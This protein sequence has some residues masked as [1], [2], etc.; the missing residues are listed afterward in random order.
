MVRQIIAGQK[1]ILAETQSVTF[2]ENEDLQFEA[3]WRHVMRYY[4]RSA[5]QPMLEDDTKDAVYAIAKYH[6]K[7]TGLGFD[8]LVPQSGFGMVPIMPPDVFG[9]NLTSGYTTWDQAWG[10][11]NVINAWLYDKAEAV[12]TSA[13][14]GSAVKDVVPRD[15][16]IDKWSMAIIGFE[17]LAPNP[18]IDFV[19]WS[20]RKEIVGDFEVG[21]KFRNGEQKYVDIGVVLGQV[22]DVPFQAG[23]GVSIA[24]RSAVRPVG[25]TFGTQTRIRQTAANLRARCQPS[26]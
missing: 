19:R 20:Q 3:A 26:T 15:A 9:I 14:Q 24:G 5:I 6:K 25:F 10:T 23:V 22:I 13:F 8:G 7:T 11:A 12:G 16:S 2:D 21:S 18:V 17:D 4:N 1:N